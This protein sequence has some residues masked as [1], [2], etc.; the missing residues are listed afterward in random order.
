M[1]IIIIIV[2]MLVAI[3]ADDKA[4]ESSYEKTK[5]ECEGYNNKADDEFDN[6]LSKEWSDGGE[7]HLVESISYLEKARSCYISLLPKVIPGVY[8][9]IIPFKWTFTKIIK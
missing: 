9:H 1:K 5:L 6:H 8:N 4:Y 7:E 2:I 3:I